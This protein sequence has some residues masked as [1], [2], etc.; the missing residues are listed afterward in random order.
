M[1][2]RE[3]L[4]A[5]A[6]RVIPDSQVGGVY[7]RNPKRVDRTLA[8]INGLNADLRFGEPFNISHKYNFDLECASHSDITEFVV[9]LLGTGT[10]LLMLSVQALADTDLHDEILK[11]ARAN[12]ARFELPSGALTGVDAVKGA[13]VNGELDEVVF[14]TVKLPERLAGAPHVEQLGIDP[15]TVAEK[16]LVFEGSTQEAALALPTNIN[17]AMALRL[18]GLG[19]TNSD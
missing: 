16:R 8:A 11:T 19:A 2:R 18:A 3:V 7:N 5:V 13:P 4:N 17:I 1:I 10:D 12:D 15:G 14:K 6:S 9:P